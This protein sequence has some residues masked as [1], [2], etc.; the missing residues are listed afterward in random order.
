VIVTS[1]ERIFPCV[2]AVHADIPLERVQ[3]AAADIP[4]GTT[5]VV[6]IRPPGR[7]PSPAS[8]DLLQRLLSGAVPADPVRLDVGTIWTLR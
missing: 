1:D 6:E 2:L 8:A 4:A 3:S 7:G 5:H